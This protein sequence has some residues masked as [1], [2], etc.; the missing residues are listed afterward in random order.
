M[1]DHGPPRR[2]HLDHY[3]V[4]VLLRSVCNF[5]TSFHKCPITTSMKVNKDHDVVYFVIL[6][7][8]CDLY[9]EKLILSAFFI[10]TLIQL[11]YRHCI[12]TADHI[13]E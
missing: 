13:A 4:H 2:I 12:Y 5:L 7:V 6:C 1:Q 10:H 11:N 3:I 9:P 8:C